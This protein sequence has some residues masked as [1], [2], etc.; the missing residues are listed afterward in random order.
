MERERGG[1]G[2][3]EGED[4][5]GKKIHEMERKG[6]NTLSVKRKKRNI[7]INRPSDPFFPHSR[8]YSPHSGCPLYSFISE[9]PSHL[10]SCPLPKG[11]ALH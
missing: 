1:R 7:D 4:E 9:P 3:G 11:G 10:S 2:K 8:T 6:E 5:E